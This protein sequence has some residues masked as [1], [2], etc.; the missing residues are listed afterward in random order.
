MI[1]AV[2]KFWGNSKDIYGM[3]VPYHSYLVVASPWENSNDGIASI[4]KIS[5][6]APLTKHHYPVL[7]GG[8]RVAFDAAID[9]LKNEPG[10]KGLRFVAHEG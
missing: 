4:V 2:V 10:N 6:E 5:T 9:A 1:R 8:E 7:Q 3:P